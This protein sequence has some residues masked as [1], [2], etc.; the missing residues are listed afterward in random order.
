MRVN[1][2]LGL[3]F[4]R[5]I[6]DKHYLTDKTTQKVLLNLGDGNLQAYFYAQE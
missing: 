4:F 3:K 1:K 6:K 2:V 5:C